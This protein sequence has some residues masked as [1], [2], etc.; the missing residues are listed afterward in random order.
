MHCGK[1]IQKWTFSTHMQMYKN[2]LYAPDLSKA[3]IMLR[4]LILTA[5]SYLHLCGDYFIKYS[6]KFCTQVHR[7]RPIHHEIVQ[8]KMKAHLMRILF[9][10]CEK[11]TIFGL[12]ILIILSAIIQE[13]SWCGFVFH[14]SFSG[15]L[16]KC[17]QNRM[18]NCNMLLLLL[19]I[20]QQTTTPQTM[21]LI[22]TN[23]ETQKA[24]KF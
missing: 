10:S 14:R 18:F 11:C 24:A 19:I 16:V 8:C 5:Y 20:R 3:N 15:F 7:S 9:L 1:F 13:S 12:K 22:E 2:V 6:S 21:I 4:S 17:N 23:L